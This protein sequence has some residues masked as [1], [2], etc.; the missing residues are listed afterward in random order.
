MLSTSE[1]C[2]RNL[3]QNARLIYYVGQQI[4]WGMLA[5]T[6]AV[7]ATVF[8]GRGQPRATIVAGIAAGLS[9]LFLIGSWFSGHPK[10]TRGRH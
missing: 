6:A 4:L 3:D 2:F 1:R 10:Q 5:G 7:L 8:D 9:G